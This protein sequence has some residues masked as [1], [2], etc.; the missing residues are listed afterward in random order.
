MEAQKHWKVKEK[1]S[2]ISQAPLGKKVSLLVSEQN[3]F[4]Y[5]AILDVTNRNV[6]NGL[7]CFFVIALPPVTLQ[8]YSCLVF[9]IVLECM[10][11]VRHVY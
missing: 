10:D 9:Q 11:P 3:A 4:V 8:P 5:E 7:Q 1:H 6:T 2:P